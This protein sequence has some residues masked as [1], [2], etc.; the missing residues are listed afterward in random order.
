M[1]QATPA[2]T[3]LAAT[4][5]LVVSLC[6]IY[7]VSQFLRN[8][9]GVIAPDLT[10]EFGLTPENLGLLSGL[11]FLS[12]AAAQIPL[13]MALDRYG[14]RAV[15]LWLS[16]L[17]I[18]A[19]LWFSLAEGF[20]G[21]TAARVLMGLGCSSFFMAPLLIYARMFS[22]SRFATLTGIQ[23]GLGSLGTLAATAPLAYISAAQGWRTGFVLVAIITG[24]AAIMVALATRGRL[25][26]PK[27]DTNAP[28]LAESFAGVISVIRQKDA[29]RLFVLHASGYP[30]FAA[31]LGLWGGPYLSDIHG[32]NLTERGDVLFVMATAQIIGLFLWGTSDRLF[33]S[34]KIPVFLGVGASAMLL[35]VLALWPGMPI[36]MVTVLLAALG[37][38]CAVT[39]VITAHGKSLFPAHLT[40]RGLTFMNIGSMGG[41][42]ALQGLTG[43]IIGQ[44]VQP[45]PGANSLAAYQAGFAALALIMVAALIIYARAADTSPFD[46][47]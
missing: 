9:I 19:C 37:L 26:A 42:F 22:G 41:S 38:C 45:A 16:G 31:M 1:T 13:G 7:M 40:G 4:A 24:L 6:V 36:G 32:L 47:G 10:R 25:P 12:F 39:P 30:V 28:G 23:L 43:L 21:L 46:E 8:S 27:A 3:G 17:A 44:F 35:G 14:P 20:A 2:R 18:I 29:L 34:R 33:R 15:M 11:F 5:F